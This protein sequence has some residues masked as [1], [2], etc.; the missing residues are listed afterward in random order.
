[1]GVVFDSCF[2]TRSAG[3]LMSPL[4]RETLQQGNPAHHCPNSLQ[5]RV[6]SSN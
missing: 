6:Q 2:G 5:Y 1:M 4:A 3:V